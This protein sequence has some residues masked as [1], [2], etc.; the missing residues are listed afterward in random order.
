MKKIFSAAVIALALVSQQISPC[1]SQVSADYASPISASSVSAGDVNADGKVSMDDLVPLRDYL[2]T[3][4]GISADS[5]RNSDMNS[6]GSLDIYD[7]VILRKML[8]D[9]IGIENYSGLLINEVCTSSKESVKDAAGESPDWIEIYNSSDKVMDISGI[10]LS[11]GAKNKFKFTFPEGTKIAADSYMLVYCDDAVNQSEGEYHAAFKLSSTGETVYL[12]HPEYGEIDSVAV[13]ELDEDVT[14]GRYKNG[15][16]NFTYLTYTPCKTNDTASIVEQS[17]K[18]LFSAE[19][20]FYDNEFSLQLISTSESVI[21]YTTDGSDPRTSDSVKKYAGTIRIYNNTNDKNI[22]SAITD[23][24]LGDYSAPKNPVDKGIVIRAVCRKADGTFGDVVTNTYFVGKN[25]PYYSDF[26]V[27]SLSTDSSNLFD[28]NTGIYVVGKNFHN[29]VASGQFVLKDNN[30]ASNPT[31]YNQSGSENEI[32]VNI[33]VFEK[34]K[35]A[36][37]GDVGA[38]I[39]GNWSRG[40]AQKSIRLY[41][42]S[43]YGDSDMKYEFIEGL[44]DINGNSIDKF[45]KVTLRNGGTDNQLLHFRDMFIQ[46]LCADRAMDIQAGEPCTLFIDGE[47]WGFYFIREK[48]DTDYVESHYGIDKNNVTFIKNG[49]LDDG[50][51][52]LDREYRD[53]LKWAATADMTNDSN[54]KKV[55]DSIDI[56]SFIDM[57]TIE[58]YINNTDWATDY[59]NNWI[60]WRATT[61]DDTCDYSDGKWRYMLYD[62]DFSADYFDDARTLAGFDTLNNMFTGSNP[63]NFVPM[64]YN[65]MNNKTFSKHFFESYTEIMRVNFAPY[66]VSKKLDEYVAKYKDVITETNTRFS[67]EWVNTNYDKEIETFRQYFINRRNLA[68]MYLDKLY[69]KEYEMNYGPDILSDESKWS[70]Y[71]EASA[72]KSNNEFKITT[73]EECKNS[74]DIQ[75]QSQQFTIEKGRTYTVTFEAACSTSKTIGVTI[76]HNVGTSWPSCFSKSGIALTPQFREYS[77]TFVSGHDSASDWRLCIDYGKGIGEYTIR[78]ASIKMISYDTELINEVGQWQLNASDDN[79]DLSVDSVNSITVN[80]HSI[81]DSSLEVEAFYSGLVLDAGKTYTVSF[82]VKSDSN[83]DAVVK[84]QKNFDYYDIYHQENISIGTTPK[85][86]KFAFKANEQC[87]DASL[88]FDCVDSAGTVEISDISIICTN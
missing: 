48:Q 6:D 46:E 28:E 68:K 85:T 65:L 19:G 12:T 73:H 54:Y 13:P 42:R 21:L 86:Y 47:F 8:S 67:Q 43:E 51:S 33:Q 26:K 74:W 2:M 81:S 49:E 7:L 62:L 79:A 23:I 71:G 17:E 9:N 45:D 53:L 60:S 4:N 40:Y 36:Y 84:L 64:F 87:M 39:S 52:A 57:V 5:W 32:P 37:T 29:L 55:C 63:Y 77:Y 16:D 61:P 31:N 78:N 80:T 75:S 50:S 82:T 83:S 76:N 70:F 30:D 20:G 14:Y 44:E 66:K 25:K 27:V 10:G 24:T 1:I 72:N 3:G 56:Q 11:D 41:A 34:G 69:G 38:R 15:S 35:L 22:Y 88:C 18:P 58:T 59:M